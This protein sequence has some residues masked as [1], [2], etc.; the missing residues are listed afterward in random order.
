MVIKTKWKV[1]SLKKT[2]G[3][4]DT[5]EE[6][7]AVYDDAKKKNPKLKRLEIEALTGRWLD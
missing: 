3:Y 7:Q 6:A 2:F 1:H 5:K 4:F